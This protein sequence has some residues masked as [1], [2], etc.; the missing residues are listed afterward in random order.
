MN[1]CSVVD[2]EFESAVSRV[3]CIELERASNVFRC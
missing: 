1:E 2:L 3:V